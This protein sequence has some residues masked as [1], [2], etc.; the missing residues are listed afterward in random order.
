MLALV[1]LQLL[2]CKVAYLQRTAGGGIHPT[3]PLVQAG[4]GALFGAEGEVGAHR[5]LRAAG[6]RHEHR[7][8]MRGNVDCQTEVIADFA[9]KGNG[10]VHV[11]A[12]A[13]RLDNSRGCK[14]DN[15]GKTR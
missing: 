14:S 12:A 15:V 9:S 2:H 1:N 13:A 6:R 10:R 5:L 4:D 11:T 8:H 3:P 7:V